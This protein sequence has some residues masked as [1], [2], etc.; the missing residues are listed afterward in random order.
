M[1]EHDD[2]RSFVRLLL[3]LPVNIEQQRNQKQTTGT[4]VDLSATGMS[5]KVDTN[6]Y[7]TQEKSHH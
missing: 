5:L 2:R 4:C 1:S 3:E 7:E 6:D